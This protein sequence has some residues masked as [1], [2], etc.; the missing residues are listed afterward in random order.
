MKWLMNCCKDNAEERISELCQGRNRRIIIIIGKPK[1]AE[2]LSIDEL[3][4]MN[5]V[6]LYEV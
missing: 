3:R 5:V 2:F 1:A 6:G 4:K